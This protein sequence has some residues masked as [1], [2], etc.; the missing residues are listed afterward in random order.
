MTAVENKILDVSNLFKKTNYNPKINEIE[1]H[2]TDH[3]HDKYIAIPEFH[4]FAAEVFDTRVA[5]TNLITKTDFA[6]KLKNLNQKI[7]SKQN[8]CLMK[9]NWNSCKH[10]IQFILEAKE[11]E[12]DG[13]FW[14]RWHTKLFPI[15]ANVQII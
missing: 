2:L 1:K 8:I 10:F 4:K 12:E 5:L 13:T 7:N 3:N 9:M 15:S 11:D 14:R 6:T